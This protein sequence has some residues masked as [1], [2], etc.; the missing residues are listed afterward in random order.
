[1]AMRIPLR[2]VGIADRNRDGDLVN[3]V[4]FQNERAG[5][6]AAVDIEHM[7]VIASF[8]DCVQATLRVQ[9][10]VQIPWKA[11]NFFVSRRYLV[12]LNSF[13]RGLRVLCN[14]QKPDFTLSY[15]ASGAV[16][17]EFDLKAL[18]ARSDLKYGMLPFA[19]LGGWYLLNRWCISPFYNASLKFADYEYMH[20][21]NAINRKIPDSIKAIGSYILCNQLKY[22]LALPALPATIQWPAF[23]G[24]STA[25]TFDQ[26]FLAK[27]AIKSLASVQKM[28]DGFSSWACFSSIWGQRLCAV[29]ALAWYAYRLARAGKNYFFV[30]PTDESI[31][32]NMYAN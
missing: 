27:E 4:L 15:E 17:H 30:T 2:D 32:I 11:F 14:Y 3:T 19:V 7:A 24:D 16:S 8:Y 18:Y 12:D 13:N 25:I 26:A 21:I 5:Y 29:G 20:A 31:K 22:H 6:L 9:K 28:N 1:M 10:D 23:T